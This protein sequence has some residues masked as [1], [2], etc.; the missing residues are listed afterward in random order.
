M[1]IFARLRLDIKHESI[2]IKAEEKNVAGKA[3]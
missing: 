1:S 3:A 2:A